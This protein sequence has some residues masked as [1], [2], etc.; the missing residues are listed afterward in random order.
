MTMNQYKIENNAIIANLKS[1]T[2]GKLI[3]RITGS[4]LFI[5][6]LPGLALRPHNEWLGK[7]RNVNKS[8]QSRAW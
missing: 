8:S 3:N 6:S 5:S 4:R 1:E 2:M 7:P